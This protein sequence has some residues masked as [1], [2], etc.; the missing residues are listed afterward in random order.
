MI[1]RY[2]FGQHMICHSNAGIGGIGVPAIIEKPD[3]EYVRYEDFKDLNQYN[4]QQ[5]A[6]NVK[7]QERILELEHKLA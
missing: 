4:D 1:K 6:E 5:I 2:G 3:G 7:L